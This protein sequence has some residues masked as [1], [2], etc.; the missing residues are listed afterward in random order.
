MTRLMGLQFKVVYR[1]GKE[2][3]AADALSRVGHLLSLQAVSEAQPIW[4]Q[5]VLNSYATDPKAQALLT[6]LTIHSPDEEGYSLE[7]GLIKY[8]SKVWIASNSALQTKLIAALH[9]TAIGGHSGG[10][11]TYHR[12]KQLF[13]W[14]GMKGHVTEYIKQCQIC[15]QAKHELIHPAGLLQPLPI[16]QGAW[17]DWS[18]D[19]IEGLPMSAGSN[20]ILVVVDRFTKYSHFLPL[21]HPF[22]AQIVARVV[23]DN[24]VKLHGFPKTIVSDR[25]KIFT[26]NFWRALFSLVDTKLQMSSAYHPQTDGQTERVNQCLEMY[27]RCAVRDMPQQWR[28]WLSLAELWYNTTYHSTLGCSPFKALYGYE[29][30]LGTML[31]V[32]TDSSSPVA[33]F[34]QQ[35]ETQLATLKTHLAAAQNR[36]KLQA[37]RSR[38]DRQFQVGERVLLKLQPYV[39]Q[40]VVS[41]PYPKLAYKFFGPFTITEKIGAAAYRLVK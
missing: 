13:H 39:Q 35:R 40:S 2:N 5:E 34:L 21:K 30:E 22:T 18:M 28:S 20:T 1:K 41:R 16:P 9:S 26:S 23:L 6:R 32:P 36:M 11:A 19:F 3:V 14:K 33:E 4:V 17:R 15:Q 37:D 27:L 38:T 12:L 24:V 25:D 8:K 31:P 7:Q 29:A 10:Q